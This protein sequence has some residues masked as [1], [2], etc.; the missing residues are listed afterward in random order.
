MADHTAQLSENMSS[1]YRTHACRPS[2]AMQKLCDETRKLE[3]GEMLT[4]PEQLQFLAFLASSIGA[5]NAIEIG[6]Y[7]GASTLAVAEILPENGTIVA[8]DATDENSNLASAAWEEANVDHKIDLRIGPA[9]GTLQALIDEGQEN[10]YDFMYIDADKTN[11]K[12]YYEFGLQLL[13]EGGIITIDN[14]FYGGQVADDSYTD[15]NTIATR[16]LAAFLIT[17]DR[18]DYS[19]LPIGDGLAIARIR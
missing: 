17:D 13:R 19:L 3:D 4:S 9:L 10:R 18:V 11:S 12:N 8:C 2:V 15:E 5:K 1:W 7:T 16:E 14:M 6:V